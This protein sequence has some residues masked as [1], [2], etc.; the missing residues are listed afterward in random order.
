MGGRT[1]MR[2]AELAQLEKEAGLA[3]ACH[4][5]SRL[6]PQAATA[7]GEDVARA[8]LWQVAP[9]RPD[10]WWLLPASADKMPGNVTQFSCPPGSWAIVPANAK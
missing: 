4:F 10:F 1:G 7:A 5:V 3:R 8:S 2:S 9:R 6:R